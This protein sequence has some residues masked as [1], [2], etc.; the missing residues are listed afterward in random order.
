MKRKHKNY[1]RPKRPFD[2][3]RIDEEVE[4]KKKYGLKNK[5]EIWKAETKI[6]KMREKAKKLITASKD[7][8]E[9]LYKQLQKI[10]LEVNSLA[11]ILG[12]DKKDYLDRRLQTI[13]VKKGL[14]TTPKTARQMIVHKRILVDGSVVNIPSFVV[15]AKLENKISVK[16]KI[17]QEKKE[18]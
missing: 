5:K 14:A 16:K 6:K 2:K 3:A 9:K 8:Q 4:I 18:E 11:D 1:S 12:L 10:G 15:P 17:K 13:V 7:E